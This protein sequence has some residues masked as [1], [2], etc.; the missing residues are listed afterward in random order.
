MRV[1]KYANGT[2]DQTR[3][4]LDCWHKF[5]SVEKAARSSQGWVSGQRSLVNATPYADGTALSAAATAN[6]DTLTSLTLTA[7]TNVGTTTAADNISNTLQAGD[8]LSFTQG[9]VDYVLT[10]SAVETGDGTIAPRVI[11]EDVDAALDTVNL[12]A[13]STDFTIA[14]SSSSSVSSKVEVCT[15]TLTRVTIK[16]H[17]IPIY[18][19]FPTGFY[20]AYLPYNYGGHNIRTPEDCGA[21]LITFCLYPGTYQPS[22]HINVSRAREFYI[23]YTTDEVITSENKGTLVVVASAIN[24]LLISDGSAVLR[25]S[26]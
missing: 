22:G 1:K 3:Q 14:R 4:Y 5:A 16:A 8:T 12:V 9:G 17:G 7:A 2:S 19:D 11:F 15:R 20:N 10:V 6:G 24:F 21:L 13:T 23:S 18:N 25:Y 26:T